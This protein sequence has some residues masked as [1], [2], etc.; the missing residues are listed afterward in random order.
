STMRRPI[1]SS[2]ARL[3]APSTSSRRAGGC[4]ISTIRLPAGGFLFASCGR[5]GGVLH[6]LDDPFAGW[7]VLLELL[8]PGGF[9]Y[10]GLYSALGRTHIVNVRSLIAERGYRSSADH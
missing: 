2:S 6:H 7:R 4:T 3:R 1:S 9:M 8:R 10:L 5:G